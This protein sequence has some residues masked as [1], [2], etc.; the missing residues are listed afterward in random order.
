M[1]KFYSL[2]AAYFWRDMTSDSIKVVTAFGAVKLSFALG[3]SFPI[4]IDFSLQPK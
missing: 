1:K 4:R 2:L 3:V